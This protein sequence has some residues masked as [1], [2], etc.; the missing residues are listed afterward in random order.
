MVS[1]NERRGICIHWINGEVSMNER[2]EQ[3]MKILKHKK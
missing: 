3:V 2:V 1:W